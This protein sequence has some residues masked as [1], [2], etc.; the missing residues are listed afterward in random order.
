MVDIDSDTKR[1]IKD[2]QAYSRYLLSYCTIGDPRKEK[3]V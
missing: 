1:E 3:R 2:Y